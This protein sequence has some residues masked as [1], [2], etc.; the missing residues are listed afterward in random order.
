MNMALKGSGAWSSEIVSFDQIK[1]SRG[2][3]S[4]WKH[5]ILR[6]IIGICTALF[7]LT[8]LMGASQPSAKANWF[9]D[10]LTSTFCVEPKMYTAPESSEG[11]IQQLLFGSPWAESNQTFLS[12]RKTAFE[13]YGTAGL[14]FP[15][16]IGG[17]KQSEITSANSRIPI[18]DPKTDMRSEENSLGCVPVPEI[19]GNSFANMSFL[20]VRGEVA[21]SSWVIEQVFNPSYLEGL[22]EATVKLINGSDGNKGLRE[23]LYL[24]F[25]VVPIFLGSLWLFWNGVFH[26]R[27]QKAISGGLW[28]AGA[29][30]ISSLLIFNPAWLPSASSAIINESTSALLSSEVISQASNQGRICKSSGSKDE[31]T[32][33]N[34][35]C[36]IWNAYAY[37][38]WV[39][40]TFGST[41]PESHFTE[42]AMAEGVVPKVALSDN[43]AEPSYPLSLLESQTIPPNKMGA[44]GGYRLESETRWNY[45]LDRVATESDLSVQTA[46]R[47][48]NYNQRVMISL[49]AIVVGSSVLILTTTLGF[50]ILIG[51]ILLTVLLFFLPLPLLFSVHPGFGRRLAM[52][53][54]EFYVGT[55]MKV[56]ANTFMLSLSLIILSVLIRNASESELSFGT[57]MLGAIVLCLAV[58]LYRKEIIEMVAGV[59]FGGSGLSAE[60]AS[61]VGSA[62]GHAAVGAALGAAGGGLAG[63]KMGAAAASGSALKRV[64][65]G[66]AAGAMGTAKGA[67]KGAVH[68]A[69]NAGGLGRNAVLRAGSV[70]SGSVKQGQAKKNAKAEDQ[71]SAAN[72]NAK[73]QQ[74]AA[75]EA[76]SPSAYSAQLD[77]DEKAQRRYERDW[78]KY[79]NDPVWAQ[80]FERTY[81]FA[82]PNPHTHTFTGYGKRPNEMRPDQ[83]PRPIDPSSS[84]DEGASPSSEQGKTG[85]QRARPAQPS[86]PKDER[87]SASM[88]SEPVPP[89]GSMPRPTSGSKPES[90]GPQDKPADSKP[91]RS[92]KKP[93]GGS[94]L[95]KP[96]LKQPERPEGSSGQ[97]LPGPDPKKPE[98]R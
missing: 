94:S 35:Q 31:Q 57:A 46:F 39:V 84:E 92:V 64:G 40:G 98:S 76:E 78:E 73:Q 41:N 60:P 17:E 36:G 97:R 23:I 67:G 77:A 49:T 52:R 20:I 14:N 32:I 74:D 93:D 55:L 28:M 18:T 47:G 53:F 88:R 6:S 68:G 43:Y 69:V 19:I 87:G 29:L 85:P 90:R 13:K 63:A 91:D 86:A 42:A 37:T 61:R 16:Y 59:D 12:Q 34:V 7:A 70:A 95:P 80:K 11:G 48:E 21:V 51:Q 75:W 45:V 58:I 89:Y 72:A 96:S 62:A 22:N 1:V 38:P 5:R 50:A 66:F 3:E 56:I 4:K 33:K 2:G 25:L 10:A 83:M 30:A 24:D 27:T 15:L 79:H 54:S 8:F 26:K 9:T 82:A 65:S 81:G 44:G 71:V